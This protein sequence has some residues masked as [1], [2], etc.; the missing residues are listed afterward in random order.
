MAGGKILDR[1]I[2]DDMLP[3]DTLRSQPPLAEPERAKAAGAPE[4]TTRPAA[5]R[6][7]E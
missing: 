6:R 1:S 2:S 4:S 3:Y 7:S 5:G